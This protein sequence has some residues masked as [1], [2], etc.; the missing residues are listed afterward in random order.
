M[1][2]KWLL[3]LLMALMLLCLCSCKENP[4][5]EELFGKLI[6]HFADRGFTCQLEPLEAERP[7]PIYNASVWYSLKLNDAEEVLVYFDESNRADYLSGFVDESKWG[8]VAQFGLRFVLVYSGEDAA[9]L[10][11][12]NA[13]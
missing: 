6:A 9:V 4:T 5:G 7:A 1:K 2:K 11:A 10:E 8:R 12:L 13:L 3:T